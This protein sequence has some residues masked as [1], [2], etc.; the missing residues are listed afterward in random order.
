[1]IDKMCNTIVN[2][3]V[4]SVYSFNDYSI[5]DLLSKFFEQINNV[6]DLVNQN[7]EKINI[8]NFKLEE[9]INYMKNE[10]I[11]PIVIETVTTMYNDGRLTE[12]FNNLANNIVSKVDE[13]K[14]QFNTQLEQKAQRTEL[15]E[16]L[17]ILETEIKQ[18]NS[19]TMLKEKYKILG[20]GTDETSKLQKA[21]NENDIIY[22]PKH[23]TIGLTDKIVIN[24]TKKIISD[25][26]T[27][28][29]LAYGLYQ[30]F[31]VDSATDVVVRGLNF[32]MNSR[33]RTSID[34]INCDGYLI[35]N[36]SFTGYSAEYDY[37]KT[38][39]GIRVENG[40]RG[41]IRN[42]YWHDHGYQYGTEL[43][44]LNRCVGIGGTSSN[45]LIE[46]NVFNKVNQ[47]IVCDS[48]DI[49][50]IGN[51]FYNVKD[52]DIYLVGKCENIVIENNIF[53]SGYDESIVIGGVGN[54]VI[55]GNTF[56]NIPNKAIT[57]TSSLKNVTITNNNFTYNGIIALTVLAYRSYDYTIT[58][59]VFSNNNIHVVG[60]TG[61]YDYI[62]LGNFENLLFSNN[63]INVST[64]AQQKII[65]LR[66]TTIMTGEISYNIFIGG[67]YTSNSVYV[68]T[69]STTMSLIYAYNKMTSCRMNWSNKITYIGQTYQT[70]VGPYIQDINARKILYGD[71]PTLGTWWKGDM[72]Y[73]NNPLPGS[74]LGWICTSG[75]GTSLGTWKS[76][77]TIE[78]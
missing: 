1:M 45:T 7:E 38:D 8:Q 72:V 50:I 5:Q 47:A 71:K 19:Y 74:A 31:I 41:I 63:I 30:I 76:I 36:C 55:N 73:N 70:N 15:V 37:Y 68:A 40:T 20:N 9:F 77:G 35:E 17:N 32:D 22:I 57:V 60:D 25:G 65:S 18:N 48:T 46:G 34:I 16:S 6:T 10:G 13:F 53:N 64:V 2:D 26:G 43:E 62:Q 39:G 29:C 78:S 66:G 21:I 67:E 69:N 3:K 33:G 44:R 56:K 49:K 59:F 52:N 75:D 61:N 4:K 24:G 27:I 11:P 28:K 12:L 42:N 51:S 14:N 54:F 23:F 58:N